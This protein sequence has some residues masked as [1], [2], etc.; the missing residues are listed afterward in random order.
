MIYTVK[1][2]IR[3]GTLFLFLLSL[4]LGGVGIFHIVRLKN[5]A[6]VILKDNYESLDYGHAMQRALESG[7]RAAFDSTLHLQ[8]MN[9]TE[10][11]ERDATENI[12]RYLP[13]TSTEI[14]LLALSGRS[15]KI[16]KPSC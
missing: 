12:R 15:G 16:F 6:Q 10:K 9:V 14:G 3:L 5:D 8:E 4:L 1:Q 13:N 11:G 2:K 7:N